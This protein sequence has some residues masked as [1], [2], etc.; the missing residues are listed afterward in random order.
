MSDFAVLV[1]GRAVN[2]DVI[3]VDGHFTGC[4]EIGEDR[5][6]QCLE[7][8]GRVS[9]AKEHDLGFEQSAVS[10]KRGL[11]FIT[12]LNADVVVPP[13]YVK[14]SEDTSLSKAVDDI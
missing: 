14:L 5:V 2:E 3:E 8:S 9:E 1:Q 10:S 13:S 11:P 12:G 7:G 4:N 6:H